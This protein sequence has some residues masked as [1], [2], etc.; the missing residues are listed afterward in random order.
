[1]G[2][3]LFSQSASHPVPCADDRSA[4]AHAPAP[5]PVGLTSYDSA[6]ASNRPTANNKSPNPSRHRQAPVLLHRSAA[7]PLQAPAGSR[8]RSR[9]PTTRPER[10]APTTASSDQRDDEQRPERAAPTTASSEPDLSAPPRPEPS[11]P[12]QPRRRPP[13]ALSARPRLH[14]STDCRLVY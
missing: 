6:S 2:Q 10:A 9:L 8:S 14:A 7:R 4:D 13:R 11:A 12:P 3:I 5:W 1:V